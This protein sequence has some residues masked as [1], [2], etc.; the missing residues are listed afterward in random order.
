[1]RSVT[2]KLASAAGMILIGDSA[3][4]LIHPR[5]HLDVWSWRGE[6]AWYRRGM[7]FLRADLRRLWALSA[8]ELAAGIGLISIAQR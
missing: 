5:G 3:A 4:H 6:P 2:R 7:S 1:M 8:L